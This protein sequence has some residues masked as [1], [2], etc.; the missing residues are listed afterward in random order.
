MK[1]KPIHSVIIFAL[2]AMSAMFFSVSNYRK[3]QYAIVKDM[4]QALAQTLRERQDQWITPDTI[5]SYRSHLSIGLLRQTSTLC[6]AETEERRRVPLA[7]RSMLLDK[8]HILGYANC[9]MLDIL[10]MSNQRTPLSL[11]LMAMLWA[12]WSVYH[13]RRKK[14]QEEDDGLGSLAYSPATDTFYNKKSAEAIRFT[15]MQHQLMQLFLKNE[16]HQLSKQEICDTLWPKKPDASET[17]YTLIR[18][19]KPVIEGNSNLSIESER[20]KSYRLVVK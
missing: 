11:S 12:M 7:S 6:Y 3:A 17:L 2:L 8:N 15:P 5:Q 1:I 13:L 19:I 20:G 14:E 4:N 16:L 10:G 9:S 18:R